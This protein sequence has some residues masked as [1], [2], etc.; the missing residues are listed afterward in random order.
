MSHHYVQACP[1]I[2]E[3]TISVQEALLKGSGQSSRLD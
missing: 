1:P 3:V 2:F